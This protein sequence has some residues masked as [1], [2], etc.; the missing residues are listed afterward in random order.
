MTPSILTLT[1]QQLEE[2][3][4]EELEQAVLTENA[5]KFR[6]EVVAIIESWEI[7]KIKSV[8]KKMNATPL[9]HQARLYL[10]FWDEK[11]AI[12]CFTKSI[13]RWEKT[14]DSY[15][16][17][18]E[19]EEN[20]SHYLNVSVESVFYPEAR[21]KL[22]SACLDDHDYDS[23]ISY[24]EDVPSQS[25]KYSAAQHYIAET[26]FQRALRRNREENLKLAYKHI[27]NSRLNSSLKWEIEDLASKDWI[28]LLVDSL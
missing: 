14:D 7:L 19:L 5:E 22:W 2:L 10:A 16:Y 26:Y 27:N 4:W 6:D 23:A 3:F 20:S 1:D 28:D 11:W 25:D 15:F 9:F 17:L 21:L 12:A 13:A 18:A 24:W 8:Y